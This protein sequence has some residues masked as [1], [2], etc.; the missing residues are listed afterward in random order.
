MVA[1]VLSIRRRLDLMMRA[2]AMVRG[3][4]PE[5][6]RDRGGGGRGGR[7]KKGDGKGR[8]RRGEKRLSE[9]CPVSNHIHSPRVTTLPAHPSCA[10]TWTTPLARCSPPITPKPPSAE[11]PALLETGRHSERLQRVEGVPP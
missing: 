2:S 11:V 3:C 8:E 1:L 5:A 4:C 9:Y 10:T 7:K 6:E